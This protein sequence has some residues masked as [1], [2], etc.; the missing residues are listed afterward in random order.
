[1][2]RKDTISFVTFV[3]LSV[4]P[5]VS[6]LLHIYEFLQNLILEASIKIRK[7]GCNLV[8]MEPKY[9]TLYTKTCTQLWKFLAELI[10]DG[11]EF[12]TEICR[13]NKISHFVTGIFSISCSS[14]DSFEKYG[15]SRQ[16][17]CDRRQRGAM[18][19]Y[20]ACQ[21]IKKINNYCILSGENFA[22]DFHFM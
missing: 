19:M 17:I 18:R 15:T 11:E 16:A 6:T 2:F 5:H 13:E 4:S 8:Q 21:V 1:M 9:R 14:L 22:L 3:G 7:E 12:Q 20:C 10:L